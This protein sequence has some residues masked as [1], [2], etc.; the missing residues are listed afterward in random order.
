MNRSRIA[1]LAGM[2]SVV[3]AGATAAV[4]VARGAPPVL[5][6]SRPT[7]VAALPAPATGSTAQAATAAGASVNPTAAAVSVPRC[8]TDMLEIWLGLGEGG[9]VAGGVY[10]PMEFTNVSAGTCSLS[11]FPGVS[12]WNGS[13][14]GS[15][16]GRDRSVAP[17]TVVLRP[18]ASGHTLLKLADLGVFSPDQCR[19]Q[20]ATALRVFP[21]GSRSAAFIPYTFQA[22]SLKGPIFMTVQALQKGLGVPGH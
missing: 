6:T 9:G 21:P 15:P 19:P 2:V 16:A 3:L 14:L 1:I 20:T 13:Q 11:G 4:L 17:S 18:G 10:Y 12:T 5:A 8:T 22:C 7:A